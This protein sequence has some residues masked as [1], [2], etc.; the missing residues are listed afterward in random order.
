MQ[1]VIGVKSSEEQL[2]QL[3]QQKMTPTLIL[4]LGGS[5]KK[6]AINLRKLFFEK[7]NLKTLPIVDFLYL[8]TDINEITIEDE[9]LYQFEPADIVDASIDSVQFENVMANLE[10]LHPHINSWFDKQKIMSACSGGVTDGAKKIRALGKL[11]FFL[12]YDE[13]AEKIE[14][15]INRIT[16]E[17]TKESTRRLLLEK[18]NIEPDFNDSFEIVLIGSLAGGTGSGSFLDIAF[19]AKNIAKK[20]VS[21]IPQ[22]TAMLCLPSAFDGLVSDERNKAYANGY[23]AL[24]ELDYYLNY[25]DA[26]TKETSNDFLIDFEWERGIKQKVS[27]PPFNTVYLLEDSNMDGKK[28]GGLE[29][30]DDI[31]RMIAEFLFLDFNESSFS[32]K[33][34]SLHSN[35]NVNLGTKTKVMF[36]DSKYTQFYPNRYS[37]FGLS[38]IKLG[39]DKIKYTASVKLAKDMIGLINNRNI[40]SVFSVSSWEKY[41]LDNSGLLEQIGSKQKATLLERWKNGGTNSNNDPI[42]GFTALNEAVMKMDFESYNE[43]DCSVFLKQKATEVNNVREEFFSYVTEELIEENPRFDTRM[44]ESIFENVKNTEHKIRAICDEQIFKSLADYEHEGVSY[45]LQFTNSL[46]TQLERLIARYVKY[47]EASIVCPTEIDIL[48]ASGSDTFSLLQDHVQES[49][50]LFPW[51]LLKDYA[52]R[53]TLRRLETLKYQ[54]REK[55]YT[56]AVESFKNLNMEVLLLVDGSLN[57]LIS[58]RVMQM[59]DNLK[60]YFED[61]KRYLVTYEATLSEVTGELVNEFQRLSAPSEN[62]RNIELSLDFDE[63][64]FERELSNKQY[65]A[66]RV[67][68]HVSEFLHG[69]QFENGLS[70]TVFSDLLNACKAFKNNPQK[71]NAVLTK[72]KI[73]TASQTNNFSLSSNSQNAIDIFY[74]TYTEP[75]TQRTEINS[76]IGYSAPRIMLT[77]MTLQNVDI[78]LLGCDKGNDHFIKQIEKLGRNFDSQQFSKDEVVFFSEIIGFPAFAVSCVG[79]MKEAYDILLEKNPDENWLRHTDKFFDKFPDLVRPSQEEAKQRVEKLKPFCM[80]IMTGIV[81]Y[82]SEKFILEKK[83]QFDRK[84]GVPMQNSLLSS[85]YS[86]NESQLSDLKRTCGL[87]FFSDLN[88]RSDRDRKYIELFVTLESNIGK[89]EQ[90]SMLTTALI[91]LQEIVFTRMLDNLDVLGRN[92]EVLYDEIKRTNIEDV[93]AS[94]PEVDSLMAS[95]AGVRDELSSFTIETGYFETELGTFRNEDGSMV[96]GKFINVLAW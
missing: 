90:T 13:F 6:S 1:T 38:Q 81:K 75:Q 71:L 32:S 45:A 12:K 23:A 88:S 63:K 89:E 7:Y 62:V 74:E 78:K 41:H 64:A 26:L 82:Q 29:A 72:L 60:S 15:K 80:A 54:Y 18:G 25:Y 22:M 47:S 35:L 79:K 55:Q 87:R 37:S 46:L 5:G 11:S 2:K 92:G 30:L 96:K 14:E 3:T 36:E 28:I 17:P 52:K 8:D 48:K 9:N 86:M 70:T 43:K 56:A 68:E 76:L 39:I 33:K 49:E 94:C 66:D 31:Y 73:F 24:K 21:K 67:K 58:S 51:P 40:K 34:R 4:A 65:Y 57:K 44:R 20:S 93:K 50:S 95:I 83:D 91:E 85:A 16:S 59:L 77:D 84:V 27:A 53:I 42:K 10:G 19:A 61:R 69:G